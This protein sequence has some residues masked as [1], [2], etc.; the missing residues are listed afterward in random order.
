MSA[1]LRVGGYRPGVASWTLTVLCIGVGL[2]WLFAPLLWSLAAPSADVTNRQAPFVTVL[3]IVLLALLGIAIWQDSGR[4]SRPL[5]IVAAVIVV[6]VAVRASLNINLGVEFNYVLP[7]GVG[8]AAGAPIGFFVGAA[9]C[10]VSQY[11]AGQ[12]A[13]P[14]PGQMFVWAFAGVLGGLLRPLGLRLA[15]LLAPF[16]GLGFGF[17]GG[18]LFNA[19]GWPTDTVAQP[20][21]RPGLPFDIN[22]V[23]LYKYGLA[24]SFGVDFMRGIATAVGLAAIGYPLCAVLQH[25]LR[26]A[27]ID[28]T[29]VALDKD[30]PDPAA[31][32]RRDR[33][34]R[35][36]NMWGERRK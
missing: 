33:S 31:V 15:W 28:R 11:I 16:V 27:P 35:V 21:F 6:N 9:S 2:L 36:S 7:I 24:T 13:N 3:S 4:E 8:I 10:L 20:G 17:V 23:G 12:V 19:I 25:A 14:L 5:G 22:L 30:E 32:A 1:R 29:P 26:P 18:L 34:R